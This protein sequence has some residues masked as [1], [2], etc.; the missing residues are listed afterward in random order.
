MQ[1]EIGYP[2]KPIALR[3]YFP[4]RTFTLYQGL[5]PA[6]CRAVIEHFDRDG[7]RSQGQVYRQATG[8]RIQMYPQ[9]QGYFR[10]HADSTGRSV[11]SRVVAMIPYLNDVAEGGETE[12]FHQGLKVAPRAGHLLLFPAGWNYM[13][14]GQVP[15]SGDKYIVQ[16]FVKIKDA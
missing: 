3:R 13:H 6:Q 10:W 7:H 14:C 1:I 4:S 9:G 15:V 2:L 8:Y 16:T 5:D 11:Q 12:F